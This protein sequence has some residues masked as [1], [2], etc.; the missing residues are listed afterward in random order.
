MIEK[1]HLPD[2]L[3]HKQEESEEIHGLVSLLYHHLGQF[4]M[5]SRVSKEGYY[6]EQLEKTIGVTDKLVE[7]IN[8]PEQLSRIK[9]FREKLN[10]INVDAEKN[11]ELLNEIQLLF[12]EFKDSVEE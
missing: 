1:P 2:K 3:N 8:N 6:K 7:K 12:H 9:A 10:D 11:L 4:L 5:G